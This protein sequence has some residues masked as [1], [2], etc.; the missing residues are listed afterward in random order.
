MGKKGKKCYCGNKGCLETY[1]SEENLANDFR[2]TAAK[3]TDIALSPKALTKK[4][5]RELVKFI[6]A[7]FRDTHPVV[8]KYVTQKMEFLSLSIA[9]LVKLMELDYIVLGGYLKYGGQNIL[10]LIQRQVKPHLHPVQQ[11][12]LTIVFGKVDRAAQ[13]GATVTLIDALFELPLSV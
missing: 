8:R 11:T 1:I 7:Q 2:Q 12:N 5:D 10:D 13:L 6:M 4:N 9:N 3:L